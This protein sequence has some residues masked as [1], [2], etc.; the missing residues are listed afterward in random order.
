MAESKKATEKVGSTVKVKSTVQRPDGQ[1][2]TVVG[3]AYVLNEPGTYVV[4]G[5]E[6]EVK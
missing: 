3:G 5:N 2:V 4:D 6:I 1:E